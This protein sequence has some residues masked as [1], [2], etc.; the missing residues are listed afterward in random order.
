MA[1]ALAGRVRRFAGLAE[2][3]ALHQVSQRLAAYLVEL[4]ESSDTGEVILSPLTRPLEDW[5]ALRDR[6]LPQIPSKDLD[7]LDDLRDRRQV[8]AFSRVGT[9]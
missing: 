8:S 6:L 1:I 3:L 4:A 5:M 7:V 2:S 9:G